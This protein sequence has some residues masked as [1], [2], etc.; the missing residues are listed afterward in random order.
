MNRGSCHLLCNRK[1]SD[2]SQAQDKMRASPSP[3][4]PTKPNA[5]VVHPPAHSHTPCHWGMNTS[6]KGSSFSFQ[7]LHT[8]NSLELLYRHVCF[9]QLAMG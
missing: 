3:G 7:T 5:R 8:P 1:H 2:G 6:L 9:V 4:S